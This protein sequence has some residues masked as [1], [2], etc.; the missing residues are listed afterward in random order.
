M[1][2]QGRNVCHTTAVS[3]LFLTSSVLLTS[4]KGN[5]LAL[6]IVGSVNTSISSTFRQT[7]SSGM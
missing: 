6:I 3:D 2:P 7:A 4:K 5:M 1:E